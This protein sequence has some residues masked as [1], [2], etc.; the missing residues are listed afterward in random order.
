MEYIDIVTGDGSLLERIEPLWTKL[1]EL[2]TSTSTHFAHTFEEFSF[3]NR[4][5]ALIANSNQG[6]LL[7]EIAVDTQSQIDIGYCIT[8]V[9]SADKGEIESIYVDPGYRRLGLGD[10]FMKRALKWLDDQNVPEKTIVV[11][12]G[13]GKMFSFY[14]KYGFYPRTTVLKQRSEQD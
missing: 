6:Q 14:Q 3:E 4:K 1:N 8:A 9:N 12:Y 2:H 13:N 5:T 10:Q 7:V 11:V